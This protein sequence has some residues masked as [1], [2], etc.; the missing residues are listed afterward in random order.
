M[1]REKSKLWILLCALALMSTSFAQKVQVG[2]DRSADFSKYRTYAWAEPAMPVTRPR[3]FAM[4]VSSIDGDLASKGLQRVEKD[5]DLLLI[6]DGGVG[7]AT[8][9]AGGAPL[10]S[11]FAGS[12]PA[13]DATVWTGAQGSGELM[14]AVP[15]GTLELQFVDRAT[16][17]VIWSGTVS[18][19]LDIEQKQKS[20]ELA[21]KAVSKL[22]KQFPPKGTASK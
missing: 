9:V 21:G 14:P 4:I 8:V 1:R 3:L 20:L 18:Q 7:F 5:G 10:V 17:R 12:P 13:I 16:N 19:K 22:L 11:T 15:D 2:Y 6:P